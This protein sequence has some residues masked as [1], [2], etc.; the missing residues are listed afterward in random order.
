VAAAGGPSIRPGETVT[1]PVEQP[2]GRA[3]ALSRLL[4]SAVRVPGTPIRFG[5]D[6]VLGLVPGL[7]DVAGAALSGYVVLLA[8]RLGAP[9]SVVAR[10]LANVAVDTA[11]GTV[12]LLGDLFDVGWKSNTRNVALLERYLE[13]PAATKAASRGVVAA[14]LVALVL[15]AAAGIALAVVVVRAIAGAIG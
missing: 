12:P 5:L 3:R 14:I 1:A 11:V 15:L 9:R 8:A 13:Q 2:V 10:M 4:D 6:A 7:G